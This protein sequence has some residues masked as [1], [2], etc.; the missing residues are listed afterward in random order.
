MEG[1]LNQEFT[2]ASL[3]PGWS[4][5]LSDPRRKTS[6]RM[7]GSLKMSLLRVGR[8]PENSRK[9]V[10]G[11]PVSMIDWKAFA[12]TDSLIVRQQRDEASAR[13]V[14]IIDIGDTMNWPNTEDRLAMNEDVRNT[15]SKTELAFRIAFWLAHTHLVSGDTVECWL[16]SGAEG[17]KKRWRPRSPADVI[18]V[19]TAAR[20]SIATEL[21]RFFEEIDWSGAR[22]DLTWLLT[23]GLDQWN[24]ESIVN[25]SR[26]TLHVQVLSSLETDVSWMDD[27]TCYLDREPHRKDYLGEQL[28]AGDRYSEK[29]TAW[30]QSTRQNIRKFSIFL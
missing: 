16:R 8:N 27:D 28:K 9:Y 10:S 30:R 6:M 25:V 22:S 20:K 14:I 7:H 1:H 4:E 2:L 24:Y 11:D 26:K 12:R 19:F 17:P 23:D 18:T 5:D 15:I 13:I 3:E 21:L 29:I